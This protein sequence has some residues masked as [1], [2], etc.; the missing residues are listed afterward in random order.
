[1]IPRPDLSLEY[2]QFNFGYD[3]FQCIIEMMKLFVGITQLNRINAYL[4]NIKENITIV[5]DQNV[6]V[7]C[8]C[9]QNN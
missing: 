3:V 4:K 9:P 1:M 2:S 7:K 8:V 5:V 6:D